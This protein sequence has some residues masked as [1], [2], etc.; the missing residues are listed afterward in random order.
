M[1]AAAG[2]DPALLGFGA[3]QLRWQPLWMLRYAARH[4]V[5][6][7]AGA[8]VGAAHVMPNEPQE[9]PP[10]PGTPV[11]SENTYSVATQLGMRLTRFEMPFVALLRTD[12]LASQGFAVRMIAALE[13]AP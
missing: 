5:E 2:D 11:A 8:G 9:V 1:H 4:D 7:F 12:D 13:L 3:R 6:V 10:L